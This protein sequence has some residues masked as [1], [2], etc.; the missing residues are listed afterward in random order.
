LTATYLKVLSFQ[1]EEM[2]KSCPLL[3]HCYCSKYVPSTILTAK[4]DHLAPES[5]LQQ[6]VNASMIWK[7]IWKK[8]VKE[9]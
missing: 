3:Q 7:T 4:D 9:T 1:I 6:Q 5:G 2:E 8:A